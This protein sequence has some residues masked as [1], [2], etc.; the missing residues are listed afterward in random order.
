MKEFQTA[1]KAAVAEEED[2]GFDLEFII[3]KGVEGR[4]RKIVAHKPSD[5]QMTVLMAFVGDDLRSNAESVSAALTFFNSVLEIEDARYIRRR[6]LNMND[7]FGANEV[8]DIL[9]YLMEEWSGK[10]GTSQGGSR[11]SRRQNGRSST[12]RQRTTE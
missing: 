11:A 12:A 1:V 9:T 2:F 10:S 8:I 5:G 4:E 3:D 7:P 6:L